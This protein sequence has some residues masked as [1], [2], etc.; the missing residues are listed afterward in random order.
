MSL[1]SKV[2]MGEWESSK[3]PLVRCAKMK[4]GLLRPSKTGYEEGAPYYIFSTGTLCAWQQQYEKLVEIANK[5][6]D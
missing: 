1:E 6:Y 5:K 2:L 3:V 4:N